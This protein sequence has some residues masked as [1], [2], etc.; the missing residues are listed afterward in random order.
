MCVGVLPIFVSDLHLC[1]MVRLEDSVGSSGTRVVNYPVDV[2]NWTWFSGRTLIC[3]AIFSSSSSFSLPP[4]LLFPPSSL[5][6][7]PPPP[8][9]CYGVCHWAGSAGKGVLLPSLMTWD[10]C[11]G[12]NGLFLQVILWFSLMLW[13]MCTPPTHAHTNKCFK[14]KARS[15]DLGMV[16]H[17]YNTSTQKVEAIDQKFILLFSKEKKGPCWFVSYIEI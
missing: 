15:Y 14:D 7:F 10:P 3:L 9:P 17:I 6:F 16:G 5:L 8:P 4:F 1:T 11:D 13:Q 2:G 12:R